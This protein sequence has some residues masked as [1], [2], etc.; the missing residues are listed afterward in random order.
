MTECLKEYTDENCMLNHM[1]I[2][3]LRGIYLDDPNGHAPDLNSFATENSEEDQAL[4]DSS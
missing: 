3:L 2:T 4:P 1:D